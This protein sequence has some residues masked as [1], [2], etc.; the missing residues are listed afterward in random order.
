MRSFSSPGQR[1]CGGEGRDHCG[2]RADATTGKKAT[3]EKKELKDQSVFRKNT[4]ICVP[5][6]LARL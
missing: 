1:Q 3:K 6:R 2:K 4:T 5:E